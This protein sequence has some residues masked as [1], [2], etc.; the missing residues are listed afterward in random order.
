MQIVK[1]LLYDVNANALQTAQ[2][3]R[4]GIVII[5]Q[6]FDPVKLEIEVGKRTRDLCQQLFNSPK[7]DTP[8][9]CWNVNFTKRALSPVAIET[10]PSVLPTVARLIMESPL[11]AALQ[12][13]IPPD[14]PGKPPIRGG[15]LRFQ[16]PDH[17]NHPL[18]QDMCF[19]PIPAFFTIWVPVNPPGQDSGRECPGLQLLNLPITEELPLASPNDI[20]LDPK[21]LLPYCIQQPCEAFLIRPQLKLGDALLFREFIPHGGFIP[22]K[23]CASR[24]SFDFRIPLDLPRAYLPK[25]VDNST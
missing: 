12:S 21:S 19:H 17:V 2:L 10:S 25:D 8:P 7:P 20:G 11:W 6:L 4:H 13:I 22:D 1:S 18:H 5:R 16:P 24:V 14:S 23:A 15:R 3:I 9:D